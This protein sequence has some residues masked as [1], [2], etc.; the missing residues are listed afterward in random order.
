MPCERRA[1]HRFQASFRWMDS[2]IFWR[3]GFRQSSF[4]QYHAGPSVH[5]SLRLDAITD[6]AARL[7]F[8]LSFDSR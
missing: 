1:R 7:L 8:P 4:H 3:L 6:F 2:C 5:R